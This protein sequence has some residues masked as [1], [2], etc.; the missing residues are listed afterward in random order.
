MKCLDAESQTAEAKPVSSSQT[1]IEGS[2]EVK[3]K[4]IEKR[5]EELELDDWCLVSHDELEE[6]TNKDV[7]N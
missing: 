7:R 6:A 2:L 5:L 4:G 1:G 3:L